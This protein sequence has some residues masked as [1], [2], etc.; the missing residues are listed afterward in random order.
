MQHDP[1]LCLFRAHPGF[2]PDPIDVAALAGMLLAQGFCVLPRAIGPDAIARINADLDEPFA[3]T[4]FGEG[5]F[6]GARTKRFGSL[7]TRSSGAM[8]LVLHDLVYAVVDKVLSPFCD[9]I[10]LN[11]TQAIAVHPGAPAQVPHRDQD[12]WPAPKGETEYLVN[13]MWPLTPFR[14]GN[15]GTLIWPG[16]QGPMAI[17]EIPEDKDPLALDLEPGD[18]LLFLGSTLHAAGANI[19]ET[20]RRGIVVGYSLGWLK[21]YESQFLAYP[22]AVARA[23]PPDLAALVG[24][25]QHRPN[26]GNYEGQCP[27]VLLGDDCDRPLGAVDALRPDQ[28]AMVAAHLALHVPD[29][30]GDT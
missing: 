19:A 12:M 5:A 28:A 14:R 10:Q 9:C 13:V 4:P 1:A 8:E 27:S 23:F 22:P 11:T 3:Q 18:A 15:G 2:G 20:E 7:L 24:Y 29:R 26:L 17:S 25:R 16:S 6:Y 21:A 30:N